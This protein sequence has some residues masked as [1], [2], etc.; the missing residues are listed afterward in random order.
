MKIWL[1]VNSRWIHCFRFEL[2]M[3]NQRLLQTEHVWVWDI[4]GHECI[5]S[6]Y[7]L[8]IHWGIS[9]YQYKLSSTVSEYDKEDRQDFKNHKVWLRSENR[10]ACCCTSSS[11]SWSQI[12]YFLQELLFFT[13]Q[14]SRTNKLSLN[15]ISSIKHWFIAGV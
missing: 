2:Y 3:V 9:P 12:R 15:E 13:E 1:A 7:C 5:L 4:R 8:N 11:S 10:L 6:I 14:A